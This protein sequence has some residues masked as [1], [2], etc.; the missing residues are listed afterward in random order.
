MA[1][2]THRWRNT[3]ELSDLR[4]RRGGNSSGCRCGQHQLP[5]V[6]GLHIFPGTVADTEIIQRTEP[7]RLRKALANA[8][9]RAEPGKRPLI[10]SY[11]L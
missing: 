7:E 3:N 8:K 6:W 11:D 2:L 10:Q 1:C 5:E 4:E 9:A